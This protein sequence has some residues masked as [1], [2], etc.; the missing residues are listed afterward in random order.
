MNVL[1]Y[2]FENRW[3]MTPKALETMVEVVLRNDN[4]TPD[5]IAKAMHGSI[6][7]KYLDDHGNLS[8]FWGLEGTD[9]PILEGTRR[10]SVADN[11]AV[12]PVVGPIF[13]RANLMTLSGGASIQALSYDFNIALQNDEIDTIIMNYDTPGGSLTGTSEFAQMLFEAQAKK[14]IISYIY[15]LGASAGYWLAAA[16]SEIII[17]PTGE[18]G[19]I[20]VVAVYSSRKK[21]REKK[22]IDEYEIVSSQSPNK[23]PDPSTDAGRTQIQQNVDSV[24]NVFI[25]TIA[26]YRGIEAS[27]VLDKYGQGKLFVGEEAIENGLAD[28]IG[29]LEGLIKEHRKTSQS[30]TFFSG[31]PMTLQELQANHPDVYKEAVAIGK[32]EAATGI[33]DKIA[34]ARK[35]GAEGE[36]ARIKSIEAIQA[37]GGQK[38]IAEHKFDMEMTADKVSTLIL[39]SQKE[40]LDNMQGNMDKDGAELADLSAGLGQQEPNDKSGED[41]AILSA[42]VSGINSH[43]EK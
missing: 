38:V 1:Q 14:R 20:G 32:K 29:S 41:E 28:R 18:A 5:A 8:D 7:E 11:V 35:E 9:Y 4:L 24:A 27:D 23:R 37:P 13:P 19:S 6:W 40:A 21:E 15:G 25:S 31:G 16:G 42:M 34:A 10:V 43:A 17:S 2:I 36:N 30:I 26:K 33:E 3:A 39:K 12:L 22:G